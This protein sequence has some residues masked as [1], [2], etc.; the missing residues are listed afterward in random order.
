MTDTAAKEECAA[1][2]AAAR[3]EPPREE[4]GEGQDEQREQQQQQQQQGEGE[5]EDEE[6]EEQEEEGERSAA[7]PTEG[8]SDCPQEQQQQ[9]QQQQEQQEQQHQQQQ[10]QQ[11]ERQ[12][13]QQEEAGRSEPSEPARRGSGCGRGMYAGSAG[14]ESFCSRGGAT[15]VASAA[16]YE[17]YARLPQAHRLR[18]TTIRF[19]FTHTRGC[20]TR[21]AA[22]I[23]LSLIRIWKPSGEEKLFDPSTCSVAA[24]NAPGR[25]P[26]S[27]PPTNLFD[28]RRDTK[29]AAAA[30]TT[31]LDVEFEYPV[32]IGGYSFV[33]AWDH[34]EWDPTAWI[35]VG[36]DG[37]SGW[38]LLD[39]REAVVPP[40]R[41]KEYSFR[42]LQKGSRP[43]C[44]SLAP[45][46]D[47]TAYSSVRIKFTNVQGGLSVTDVCLSRIRLFTT[48]GAEIDLSRAKAGDDTPGTL[49]GVANMHCNRH[50]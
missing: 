2:A 40:G 25:N 36:L 30:K 43:R 26:K 5:K 46:K 15:T 20:L 48:K 34:P 23:H 17:E 1:L 10:Q 49:R 11:Q 12:Q 19:V 42:V 38:K 3:S 24:R 16:D 33:S 39:N 29:W 31:M 28:G 18:F 21:T 6:E 22:G 13:Q 27:A 35:L 32:E 8:G 4:D 37:S 44:G 45:V 9:Q 14:G 41:S 7:P 47:D 50:K